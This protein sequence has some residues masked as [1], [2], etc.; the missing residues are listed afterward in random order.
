[1]PLGVSDTALA[2]AFIN[3]EALPQAVQAFFLA[4]EI[5]FAEYTVAVLG[6][7]VAVCLCSVLTVG[8]AAANTVAP[9]A[10]TSTD[11]AAHHPPRLVGFLMSGAI[12]CGRN[13]GG[14]YSRVIPAPQ[15]DFDGSHRSSRRMP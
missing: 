11:H 6:A 10:I 3:S 4:A 13:C 14:G 5:S 2:A 9:E 7:G 12:C 8:A 15:S 1:Q